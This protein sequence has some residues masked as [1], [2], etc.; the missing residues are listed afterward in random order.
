MPTHQHILALCSMPSCTHEATR[1]FK[2]E[3]KIDG[4]FYLCEEHQEKMSPDGDV[5]KTIDGKEREL[6]VY[7][8]SEECTYCN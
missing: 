6:A 8:C 7:S 4:T 3:E 2:S 5:V 1:W